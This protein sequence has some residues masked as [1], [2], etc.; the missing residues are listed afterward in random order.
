MN[1]CG[2]RGL[3]L[4]FAL[5]MMFIAEF[6]NSLSRCEMN[7]THERRVVILFQI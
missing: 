1:D 6:G 4:T 2:C 5:H 3:I 7:I